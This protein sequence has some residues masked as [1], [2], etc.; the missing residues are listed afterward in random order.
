MASEKLK[1]LRGGVY[2]LFDKHVPGDRLGDA[3]ERMAAYE[4]ALLD[5]HAQ[6][7]A[8]IGRTE[9]GN[10]LALKLTG[11]SR[12]QHLHRKDGP[13]GT[14]GCDCP[15]ITE[16]DDLCGL[17]ALLARTVTG[18]LAAAEALAQRWDSYVAEIGPALDPHKAASDLRAALANEGSP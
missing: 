15:G 11:S 12:W 18:P 14:V 1:Q 6:R 2:W 3:Y 10:A 4:K 8:R 9:L 5:E 7:A 13:C 17:D 16:C